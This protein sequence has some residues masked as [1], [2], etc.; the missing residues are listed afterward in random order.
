MGWADYL[1]SRAS[2]RWRAS[3]KAVVRRVSGT[4]LLVVRSLR[5]MGLRSGSMCRETSKGVLG[6]FIRL[7][8]SVVFA[9]IAV[10]GNRAEGF[11]R[12]VGH[13]GE[14]FD[15]ALAQAGRGQNGAL[16][17]F[18]GIANER[19]AF[20][21]ASLESEL[22]LLRDVHG[23]QPL[24]ERLAPHRVGLGDGSSFFNGRGIVRGSSQLMEQ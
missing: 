13:G 22:D 4:F 12:E 16:N 9:E 23:G 1:F 19:A 2:L 5:S 21:R 17:D 6:L 3:L 14:G 15:F 20:L 11:I 24:E 18:I 7:R 8:T 10:V